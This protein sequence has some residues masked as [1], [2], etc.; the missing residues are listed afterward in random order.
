MDFLLGIFTLSKMLMVLG[1]LLFIGGYTLG[2][3]YKKIKQFP[4]EVTLNISILLS[5]LGVIILI[6]GFVLS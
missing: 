1:F 6:S 5:I 4:P 2:N 3:K